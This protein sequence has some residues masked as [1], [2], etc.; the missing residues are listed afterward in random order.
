MIL[1]EI[2]KFK[3]KTQTRYQNILIKCD[4][5]EKEFNASLGN[6]Q[7]GYNKYQKDLCRGCKQHEQ[8]VLG[9]RGK[10]Y[11][12]AGKSSKL[13]T[14]KNI[15]EILG[16]ER[17]KIFREK[18]SLANKGENNSNFGGKWHGLNPASSQ[19]GKTLEDL[20]GKEKAN[21]IKNKIS[22][23]SSGE[24]NSMYGK[25]SPPGSGNGWS[26]WY[27]NWYFRSLLELSFMINVIERFNFTWLGAEKEK[28]KIHYIDWNNKKRTYH[29][30]FVLNE[31]YLIEIKPKYLWNS[32]TVKR[33]CEA[34]KIFCDDRNLKFKI[35]SCIK[36]LTHNEIEQ[37][38]K[39]NKVKFIKR[40]Q[41]K[42]EKQKSYA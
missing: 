39:E 36:L 6:Q 20:Y 2:V 12:N 15:E 4:N 18:C 9:I 16:E 38:I 27:N 1:S 25:P 30:D 37:L 22:I 14:G 23:A 24:N 21:N 42:W 13:N 40:Y 8:V 31:K 3:G 28:Y 10:Q 34:A 29:P 41:E 26:G 5:C 19:K 7:A 33:K 35:T 11:I 17:G 32:E